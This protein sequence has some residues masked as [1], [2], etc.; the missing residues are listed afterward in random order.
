MNDLRIFS[1]SLIEDYAATVNYT[2]PYLSIYESD[3][4]FSFS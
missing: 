3:F 4:F 2:S 1:C